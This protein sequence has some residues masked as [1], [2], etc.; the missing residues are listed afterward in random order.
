MKSLTRGGEF[1]ML[2]G[3]GGSFLMKVFLLLLAAPVTAWAGGGGG[4]E[5]WT[6]GTFAIGVGF[7]TGLTII[8]LAW[9]IKEKLKIPIPKLVQAPLIWITAY[10]V[11]RVF[12]QPPIPFTLLAIYMGVATIATFLY[13]SISQPSWDEFVRPIALMLDG[14][15]GPAKMSRMVTF[16][17]LPLL[18]AYG[19]YNK[20]LPKF[21]EPIELRTVHPAPPASINVHDKI[22][23]L[24]TAENPY[25]VD[26]SGQYL[27][28]GAESVYHGKNPWDPAA[29]KFL[30]NV[31]DGGVVFFG[32]AGCF[33]CHGDNLDGKGPFAF[34]FNPIP[35]NFA[36]PGTI[37]QLQETFV[38]WRVAKGGPGLTRE[39][40]PWASA[41]PPWEKH[42]TTDEMWRV[43]LF[44]YWHTGF[45]PR[46]WD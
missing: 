34:A 25:R 18:L 19:T 15:P 30:Q 10:I 46:T 23:T 21:E 7:G 24:Q 32:T 16:T 29:P 36:D 11:F 6:A 45:F 40:F 17:A 41:M 27:K 1:F 26:D 14:K 4:G 31:R 20:M 2:K 43:I 9:I 42:L 38:F 33:F 22:I 35:A 12:L 3:R 37:A 13:V 39:G 28:V 5:F 8:I 44:E